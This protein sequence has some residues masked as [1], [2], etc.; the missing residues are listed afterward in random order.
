MYVIHQPLKEIPTLFMHFIRTQLD[1]RFVLMEGP[2]SRIEHGD[3]VTYSQQNGE[4]GEEYD[5]EIEFFSSCKGV[6]YK[7]VYYCRGFGVISFTFCILLLYSCREI[8]IM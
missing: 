8:R 5:I 3:I 4:N 7:A 6:R 1:L 2:P